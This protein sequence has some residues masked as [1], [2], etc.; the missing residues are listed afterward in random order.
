[1]HAEATA[2]LGRELAQR[3]AVEADL[4]AQKDHLTQILDAID[5]TVV[6]C[7][8]DG[9]IVHANRAAR[10]LSPADR[11]GPVADA[12]PQVGMRH[13]DGTPM[14]TDETPMARALR[15]EV[16][17]DVEAV[18]TPPDG[19]RRHVMLHARPLYDADGAVTGAVGSSYDI[20]ALR[21][22]EAE[23]NAFAGVVAH[24]LRS[25]LTTVRGFTELVRNGLAVT[26]AT[27]A[28]S[29][30]AGVDVDAD[31]AEHIADLD[32]VLEST[33]RMSELI[34]DLLDYS[35]AGDQPLATEDLDLTALVTEVVAARATAASVDPDLEVPQVYVARLLPVHG[36]GAL[37]RQVFDNLIG[38]A[39]K[40]TPPGRPAHID[41][42]AHPADGSVCVEVSDRGIGIP[43]GQHHA[44]FGSFQRAHATAY[45][46]TGL[47]LAICQR[48]VH[49]HGGT[50]SAHDNPG[51]GT[52]IRLTLPMAAAATG[53]PGE[54]TGPVGALA[55][56]D[57][58][59]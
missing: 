10:S 3:Q 9:T 52:I 33:A 35:A 6:T 30:A 53:G 45:P 41:V 49:R 58:S 40:Y 43:P 7:A 23:L 39:I 28:F 59:P 47:G 14:R 38:N 11:P 51:G 13:P 17:T 26:A 48:I 12:A 55:G 20:T 46:G 2:R 5:V 31:L 1:V 18:V 25:P 32:R 27:G 44:I 37:L 15:G 54:A 8:L 22:R 57:A 29:G 50:V 4:A 21:E 36:D 19:G 16:V 34:S 24:D 42:T 56:V